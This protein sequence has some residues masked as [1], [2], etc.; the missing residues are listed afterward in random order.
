MLHTKLRTAIVEEAEG[1]A[2]RQDQGSA[3]VG[4]PQLAEER[5]L[6]PVYQCCRN[7]E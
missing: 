5:Y 3:A 1:A 4:V 2:A 7:Q 6:T